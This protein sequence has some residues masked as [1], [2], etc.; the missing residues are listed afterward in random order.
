M[1]THQSTLSILSKV[2]GRFERNGLALT[3]A[4]NEVFMDRSVLKRGEWMGG[5]EMLWISSNNESM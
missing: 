1:S 2:R 5:F 3:K 4:G